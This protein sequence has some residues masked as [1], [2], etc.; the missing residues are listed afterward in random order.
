LP[1]TLRTDSRTQR[2]KYLQMKSSLWAERSSF[3]AHWRE[4]S[5]WVRPRRERFTVTDRNRG[6][7]R[8]EKII[9]ST[10]TYALR[11]LESGMQAGLTSPARPW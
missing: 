9:D 5:Q 4:L 3:E 2:E 6:D 8:N 7:R 11:T 10:G 1:E